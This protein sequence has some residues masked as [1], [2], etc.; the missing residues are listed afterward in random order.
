[1]TTRE[2]RDECHYPSRGEDAQRYDELVTYA[3][4]SRSYWHLLRQVTIPR[5]ERQSKVQ[6]NR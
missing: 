3:D 2:R 5:R 6:T 4:E 1:M